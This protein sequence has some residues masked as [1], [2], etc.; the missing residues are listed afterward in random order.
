M[1]DIVD[2]EIP[3]FQVIAYSAGLF[4]NLSSYMYTRI[5]IANSFIFSKLA[6]SGTAES[7]IS[8]LEKTAPPGELEF[9]SRSN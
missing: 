2:P 9:S 5:F 7:G 4:S 8:G 1:E 6:I 3:L